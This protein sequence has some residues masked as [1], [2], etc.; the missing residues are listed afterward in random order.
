MWGWRSF[1]MKTELS[2][3]TTIKGGTNG[4][5][6]SDKIEGTSVYNTQG[7]KLGSVDC[8]MIDKQKGSVAY[9][10]MSFGGFLGMGEKRHPMPW[11][12]LSYDTAKDG[13][14]VNLSKE[15][16]ESAPSLE[17]GQYSQLGDRDFDESVY[18][19]Y[20]VQPYWV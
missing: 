13:Y 6:G 11:Q 15:Q 16:L 1:Q 18:S 19:H 10:V 17:A 9:A 4:L 7:E 20:R 12:S 8:V 5:I 14:V 3:S 2:M